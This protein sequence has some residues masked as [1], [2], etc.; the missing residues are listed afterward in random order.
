MAGNE[1]SLVDVVGAADGLIAKAQMADEKHCRSS[2]ESYW[3]LN[4]VVGMVAND[5]GGVLV[6]ADSAVAETP[7][8][9]LLVPGA[10]VIGAGLTSGRR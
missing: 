4:A 5:L 1:V 7:E 9:A 6:C 3:S 2:L 8:L 10:E